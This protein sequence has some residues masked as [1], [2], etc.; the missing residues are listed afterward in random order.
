MPF[1]S[2]SVGPAAWRSGAAPMSQI[3]TMA[4]TAHPQENGE[5]SKDGLTT[6]GQTQNMGSVVGPPPLQWLFAEGVAV[7]PYSFGGWSRAKKE[8]NLLDVFEP[9]WGP[10]YQTQSLLTGAGGSPATRSQ[11][12]V[13]GD[14]AVHVMVTYAPRQLARLV[15]SSSIATDTTFGALADT[16]LSAFS[17]VTATVPISPPPKPPS[18]SSAPLRNTPR[19]NLL[20]S[21]PS[22]T[23]SC[24]PF[25]EQ[26][27]SSFSP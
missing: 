18:I 1:H 20:P 26:L 3:E 14:A 17:S 19:R 25:S 27:P 15:L 6:R 9:T 12:D 23:P 13:D 21:P 8:Y 11:G 2:S 24:E 4:D 5:D 7:H 10:R 16:I 22:A